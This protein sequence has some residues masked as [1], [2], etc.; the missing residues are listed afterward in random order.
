LF[1][2]ESFG[3]FWKLDFKFLLFFFLIL[4]FRRF[5]WELRV[6]LDKSGMIDLVDL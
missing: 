6:N 2:A 3:K 4:F 1:F 5:G